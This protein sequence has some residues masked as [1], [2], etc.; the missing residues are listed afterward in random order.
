MSENYQNHAKNFSL[1]RN[2]IL[3]I[4]A[5]AG[6]FFAFMAFKY[7]EMPH[8]QILVNCDEYFYSA[9]ALTLAE[10]GDYANRK[11]FPEGLFTSGD[12]YLGHTQL[13]PY[14]EALFIKLFGYSRFSIR[15][16]SVI[17]F[18]AGGMLLIFLWIK[19]QKS[20]LIGAV[21]LAAYFASPFLIF[22]G[23]TAR[24]E[25]FGGFLLI[26]ACLCIA[27]LVKSQ[28]IG[29]FGAGLLAGV[30]T[31]N[32]PIFFAVSCLPFLFGLNYYRINILSWKSIFGFAILYGA[33]ALFSVVGIMAFLVLPFYEQWVEQFVQGISNPQ[34]VIYSSRQDG[35]ISQVLSLKARFST[36]GFGYAPWYLL[37]IAI[38]FLLKG[39]SYFYLGYAWLV[40][41]MFIIHINTVLALGYCVQF[42]A[43][44]PILILMADEVRFKFLNNRRF[45]LVFV[46]LACGFSLA[47][48][49]LVLYPNNFAKEFLKK[50]QLIENRLQSIPP[51]SK[52]IGP[53][54]AAIPLLKS[55]HIY[56]DPSDFGFSADILEKYHKLIWKQASYEID[57]DLTFIYR[58]K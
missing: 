47:H 54:E 3:I 55:G 48:I 19:L 57:N 27:L 17:F 23:R 26:S 41:A 13:T 46:A 2:L 31:Y 15:L 37:V 1:E 16:H 6:C 45:V 18:L 33:G 7:I 34:N 52:V 22:A 29:F 49:F 12:Q 43:G 58:E 42:A 20:N 8:N 38:P 5:I 9:P 4:A 40:L 10:S 51:K 32:H 35:I 50:E 14:F 21:L 44:I 39:R 24:P 11:T 30:A 28:K 25:M 56:F 36:F 53:L